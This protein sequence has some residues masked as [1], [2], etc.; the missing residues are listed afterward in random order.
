MSSS[1]NYKQ[2]FSGLSS[3]EVRD[4]WEGVNF[5]NPIQEGES[6]EIDGLIEGLISPFLY[7][8]KKVLL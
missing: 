8:K 4:L 6:V 2:L 7:G 1:S 3:Q 5:S